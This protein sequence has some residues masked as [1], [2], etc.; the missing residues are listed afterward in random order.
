MTDFG[1]ARQAGH[2]S[3]VQ[4]ADQSSAVEAEVLQLH[5]APPS[6]AAIASARFKATTSHSDSVTTAAELERSSRSSKWIGMLGLLALAGSLVLTYFGSFLLGLLALATTVA[7][8][9]FLRASLSRTS[10]SWFASRNRVL[11]CTIYF[12]FAAALGIL[13][14]GIPQ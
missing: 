2:E 7:A 10:M 4:M 13:A 3:T 9:G 11:D 5:P 6:T 1:V 12:G 14:L 8:I